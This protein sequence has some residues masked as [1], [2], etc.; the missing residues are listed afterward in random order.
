VQPSGND[1]GTVLLVNGANQI[2]R[3]EVSLGLQTATRVEI[4]SGVVE[5]D[6]V[7]FGSQ[8]QYQPG[9]LVRPK[10]IEAQETEQ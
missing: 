7:V 9:E 6:R 5:N 8:G 2:E 3:R 4:L 1:K 10:V